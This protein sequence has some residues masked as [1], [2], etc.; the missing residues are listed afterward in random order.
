MAADILAADVDMSENITSILKKHPGPV[1]SFRLDSSKWSDD[2][3]LSNWLELLSIKS[4]QEITIVNLGHKIDFRFPIGDVQSQQLQIL[5]LG[6]IG[7][8]D[9]DLNAF[10]YSSLHILDLF[11]CSFQGLKLAWIIEDCACLRELRVSFCNENLKINSKS[12]EVVRIWG[13]IANWLVIESAPK[14]T[15]IVTGIIPR[16]SGERSQIRSLRC[17]P[18]ATVSISYAPS[19]KKISYLML[20][21]HNVTVNG[22][23]IAKVSTFCC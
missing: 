22:I 20:P 6:F 19:L 8:P 10:K 7:L 14:L 3:V 4:A 5:R 17:S 23:P 15:V 21:Y 11:S 12:L 9:L 16:E 18:L 13:S 2:Q 1:R